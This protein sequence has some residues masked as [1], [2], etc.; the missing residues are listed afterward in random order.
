MPPINSTIILKQNRITLEL[1]VNYWIKIY[2]LL[3]RFNEDSL[4]TQ[5]ESRK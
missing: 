3:Y 5:Y 4:H 2:R 1:R